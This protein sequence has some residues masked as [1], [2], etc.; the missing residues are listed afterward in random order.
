MDRIVRVDHGHRV[1]AGE[2]DVEARPVVRK[3]ERGRL[4]AVRPAVE[5]SQFGPAD[6]PRHAL[7]RNGRDPVD[8]A[9]RDECVGAVGGRGDRG[10][11]RPADDLHPV[12]RRIHRQRSVRKGRRIGGQRREVAAGREREERQRR[13]LLR[14]GCRRAERGHGGRLRQIRIPHQP[15]VAHQQ[16]VAG[17]GGAERREPDRPE[18][19]DTL[20]ARVSIAATVA[21]ASLTT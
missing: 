13:G 9:H 21:A 11:V 4:H 5:Q 14:I 1:D 17:D 7:E 19:P 12:R 20:R 6:H 15:F 8:A 3:C 18:G 16:T 2:R 10:R